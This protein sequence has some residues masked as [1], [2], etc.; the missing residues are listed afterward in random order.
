MS[1]KLELTIGEHVGSLD[2]RI[3]IPGDSITIDPFMVHRMSALEDSEYLE[4]ST[5]E[6]HDV[7]RL[8]DSYGRDVVS[9]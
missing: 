9:T 1:G 2:K 5:T 7:V 6:L 8:E 4:A 3:L